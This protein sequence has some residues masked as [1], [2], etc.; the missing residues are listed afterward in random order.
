MDGLAWIWNGHSGQTEQIT[1]GFSIIVLTWIFLHCIALT[2]A[3]EFLL[4][5]LYTTESYTIISA[6]ITEEY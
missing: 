4:I 3:K 6:G 2:N 1:H 5:K